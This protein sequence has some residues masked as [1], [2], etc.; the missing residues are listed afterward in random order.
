MRRPWWFMREPVG[1]MVLAGLPW[2][3]T[4]TTPGQ[5]CREEEHRG[6]TRVRPSNDLVEWRSV[7]VGMKSSQHG[8]GGGGSVQERV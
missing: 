2:G 3:G 4:M 8:V 1:V 5:L 7:Y 6:V